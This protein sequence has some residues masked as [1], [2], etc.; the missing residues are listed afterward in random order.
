[1][2][3]RLGEVKHYFGQIGVAVLRIKEG[4]EV[5]NRISFLGH[6]TDFEQT[7]TSMEI[8]H[9]KV[10][11]VKPGDD[12]AIKVLEKVRRGDAV[13]IENEPTP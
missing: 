1:M 8:D 13:Y 5:G 11:S 3:K 6:T 7:V 4:L 9:K 2:K 12:F 10:T